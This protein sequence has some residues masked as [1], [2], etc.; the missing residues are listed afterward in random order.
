MGGETGR[1]SAVFADSAKGALTRFAIYT[2]GILIV[3]A[4]LPSL[5]EEG[6]MRILKENGL[7]E[8]C[9]FALLGVFSLVFLRCGFRIPKFR[10]LFFLMA[11]IALFA[12]VRELDNLL[13]DA[14]PEVGWKFA[15]LFLLFAIWWGWKK[16]AELKGQISEFVMTRAFV[17]LWA[18]AMIVVPIGQ[19]VGHGD[20]LELVMGDDYTRDY[21]RVVEEILELMGIL[22]LTAGCLECVIQMKGRDD[23]AS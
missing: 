9:Q 17:V 16:R 2:V 1:L 12:T 4:S 21:K 10:H 13:D 18:G 8:W 14:I 5:I 3:T 20:L 19:L 23:G 11:P 22:V 15:Y 6:G 7:F